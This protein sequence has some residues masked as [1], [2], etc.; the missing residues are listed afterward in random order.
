MLEH[1]VE[2]GDIFRMCQVKDAPVQDWVK[3]AVSRARA[4]NSP[5]VFWLDK[6]RPHDIELIKKVEKYLKNFN[7]YQ[8]SIVKNHYA[9]KQLRLR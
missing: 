8:I 6:N 9:P 2:K 1:E 3:L 5:A 7:F 4:T